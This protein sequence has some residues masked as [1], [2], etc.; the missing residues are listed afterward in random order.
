MHCV[1]IAQQP[2]SCCAWDACSADCWAI[3]SRW[4]VECGNFGSILALATAYILVA[5]MQTS[6]CCYAAETRDDNMTTSRK[7]GVTGRRTRA[8]RVRA[9]A[10][11]DYLRRRLADDDYAATLLDAAFAGGDEGDIM[12][13]LREVALAKDGVAGIAAAAGLSRETLYRTLSRSGNPRLST[14]LAVMRAA[15]VRLKVESVS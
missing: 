8:P 3:A 14:L 4:E 12:Y 10:H 15:G 9:K 7:Q 5:Q 11:T 13:A 1:T 2:R 6:F